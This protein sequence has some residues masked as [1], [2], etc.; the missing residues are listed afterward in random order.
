M[1]VSTRGRTSKVGGHHVDFVPPSTQKASRG[2]VPRTISSRNVMRAGN[3]LKVLIT[4]H[5]KKTQSP[6][7]LVASFC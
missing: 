7:L 5:L 3:D 2:A 1:V 4:S 6:F